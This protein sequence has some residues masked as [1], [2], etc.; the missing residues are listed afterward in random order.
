MSVSRPTGYRMPSSRGLTTLSRRIVANGK[1]LRRDEAVRIVAG[2]AARVVESGSSDEVFRAL[3]HGHLGDD[4]LVVSNGRLQNLV[5]RSAEFVDLLHASLHNTFTLPPDPWLDLRFE[6][7]FF[8]DPEEP[9]APWTYVLVGT[10]SDAMEQRWRAVDGVESYP[11]PNPDAPAGDED[12]DA[13]SRREAVWSRVMAPYAN[14]SPLSWMAPDPQLLFDVVDSVAAADGDAARADEGKLTV[15]L[16]AAELARLMGTDAT[17]AR[18]LL[19]RRT[20]E[21]VLPH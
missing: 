12:A 3:S 19:L 8:D 16:V 17:Q 2:V 5:G 20:S 10:E 14:S 7:R 21:V 15:T 11:L 1:A 9:E 13:A 6:I 4:D 18:E